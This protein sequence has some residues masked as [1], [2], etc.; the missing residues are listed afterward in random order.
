MIAL[1]K[2][3]SRFLSFQSR[4]NYGLIIF[5]VYLGSGGPKNYID[6]TSPAMGTSYTIRLVPQRGVAIELNQV[7]CRKCLN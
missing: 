3:Y 7:D 6:I 2:K 5:F 1:V 4:L